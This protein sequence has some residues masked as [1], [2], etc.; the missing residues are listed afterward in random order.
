M[1]HRDVPG[2]KNPATDKIKIG[3]YGLNGHQIHNQLSGHATARLTAMAGCDFE[4]AHPSLAPHPEITRDDIRQHDDLKSL[5]ADPEVELVSLCSPRRANQAAD[6]IQ[7]LRAGKHVYAEKPAALSEA[8]LDTVLAEADKAGR[9]FHE[10]ADTVFKQPYAAAKKIARSGCLGELVQVFAQKSYQP[11]LH[12]RPQDEA[13]DGGLIL[14]CGIHAI[15]MIEHTT[16]L[17]VER[18]R[19]V[20]TSSGNPVSGGELRMAAS[21]LLSLENGAVGSV[22]ANYLCPVSFKHWNNEQ[23]RLF[24]AKGFMEI[25]DGGTRTALYLEDG[26]SGPLDTSE[27]PRPFFDQYCQFILDGTPMEMSQEEE[28]HPLRVVLRAKKEAS[29]L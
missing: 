8:E 21:M 17:R 2:R 13:V 7:C 5:L 28:L 10:M 4:R 6:A 23:F 16:G 3:I 18:I 1:R 9:Q 20:E 14:Q 19:A 24:G 15:R 25:T 12:E 22:V 26:S 27:E 11:R 29:S